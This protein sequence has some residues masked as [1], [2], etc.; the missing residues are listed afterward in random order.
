VNYTVAYLIW[1]IVNTALALTCVSV[2]IKAIPDDAVFKLPPAERI[3]LS[4]FLMHI[5]VF[6]VI[7]TLIEGKK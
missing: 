2:A 7:W 4:V 3:L 1:V 6:A 5:T